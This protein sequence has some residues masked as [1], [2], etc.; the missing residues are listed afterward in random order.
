MKRKPHARLGWV[1]GD[2]W[3]EIGRK[4]AG[5]ARWTARAW[6]PTRKRYISQS[7]PDDQR[8]EAIAWAKALSASFRT[9]GAALVQAVERAP[10]D[11]LVAIATEICNRYYPADIFTGSS[12]D[13]GPQLIVAL[14]RCIAADEP[15]RRDR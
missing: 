8:A 7:F 12:G 3:K 1:I 9:H 13:P 10:W 6:D 15:R 2:R 4:K 11:T 14:R 5:V